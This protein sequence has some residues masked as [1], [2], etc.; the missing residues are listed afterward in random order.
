MVTKVAM[1]NNAKIFS[2]NSNKDLSIKIGRILKMKLGKIDLDSF[3]DGEILCEINETVRED[4]IHIIQSTCA[5]SNDNLM[6]LLIMADAFKR[7]AVKKIIAVVPYYGYARQDRRPQYSRTPVT[8]R[9]VADMIQTAGIQQ[10]VVVDLHSEQQQGF[11]TIPTTNVSAAPIIISDV[12]K[13]HKHDMDNIVVVSPDTG[14]VVRAR[15]I[16]KKLNDADLAIIDKRRPRANVSQV[17]NI[18]GDVEGKTCVIVDDM[19]DTA[20]TLCKAATAL[21]EAGA[22]RVVAY[23][24]HAVFSG[25]AYDNINNSNLDEVVVTDTIPLSTKESCDKIRVISI[26]PLIAETMRRINDGISVS[27]IYV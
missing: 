15:T 17:M 13:K 25:D 16:A 11:F 3:S 1:K 8:S 20:G 6:E 22:S 18:I 5:P 12:W 26:A 23:A 21:K 24:T 10:L 14:G 9:L 7:S 19:I 2:G 4:N 27:E